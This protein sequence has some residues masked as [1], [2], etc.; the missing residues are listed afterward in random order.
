MDGGRSQHCCLVLLCCMLQ[1]HLHALLPP[2]PC[3]AGAQPAGSPYQQAPQQHQHAYAS[4]QQQFPAHLQ[5]PGAGASGSGQQPGR[6]GGQQGLLGNLQGGGPVRQLFV[7][8][9]VSGGVH[10][11]LR[12]GSRVSCRQLFVRRSLHA[13]GL[14]HTRRWCGLLRSGGRVELAG[15]GS[16]LPPPPPTRPPL[17][18]AG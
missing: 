17:P 4:P 9:Q 3:D 15:A 1:L 13:W 18:P 16:M 11:D 6:P 10:E 5:S 12:G 8:P 7:G 14:Y 2:P